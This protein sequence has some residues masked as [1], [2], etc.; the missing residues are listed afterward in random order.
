MLRAP[1]AW[2]LKLRQLL[3]RQGGLPVVW[4]A[5][6]ACALV[7]I[8]AYRML[9]MLDAPNH[10][11]LVSAWHH[12]RDPA[13][14]IADWYTLRI[15]PVPYIFYYLSLHLLMFI[16]KIETA[17]KIFLS[18]YV[19]VFPLSVLSLA[20]ALGRSP[21]LAVA[22]F[23]LAF[24]NNWPMGFESWMMSVAFFHF[25]LAA[26]IRWLDG[27]KTR[28][29]VLVGLFCA[30]TYFAHVMT[31]AILGFAA[32]GV[33]LTGPRHWGRA[34]RAYMAM[35]PTAVCAV[36][37]YL[38]DKRDHVFMKH[39]N[40]P[41]TAAWKDFPSLVAEFPRRIL[42]LFPGNL[43]MLVLGVLAG[44][45]I[46]FVVWSRIERKE[47]PDVRPL[48]IIRALL[49]VLGLAYIS[50]PY[51]IT[52]PMEWYHVT[53][54]LPAMIAPILILLPSI[55]ISGVKRLAL[56]P[57]IAAAVFLPL[58]LTHLY[59]GFNRRTQPFM[60]LVEQLPPGASTLVV[61]RGM[62]SGPVWEERSGD[63]ATA[64]A[65]FWHYSTWPVALRG[66]YSP[67]L[68]D[69]GVPVRPKRVL[70]CPGWS[71]MDEFQ[72]RQAPEFDYYLVRFADEELRNP[73]VL[74][75][76]ASRGEWSLFKR[77][78]TLTEEP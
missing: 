53:Q 59:K 29:L 11:A 40:E 70:K 26:L 60:S 14:H 73:H 65:V 54:R 3:L 56:L 10:M 33:V 20:R 19:I 24:N 58:Q 67:Y 49:W 6:T 75:L 32:L 57:T 76:I 48:R 44:T 47:P 35:A 21:W 72:L 63:P 28:D 69:Q 45:T 36:F 17:N 78:G 55:D 18:A 68:F 1:M 15:R 52:K 71:K 27:G 46:A 42:D 64:E 25:T 74:K 9:P 37:A 51:H 62:L 50:L 61:Y 77:V 7:P 23:P 39:Q 5:L 43:D 16:V 12:Y 41:F 13:W 31:W 22:A 30:L 8:W 66:G 34:V 4:I 2:L 38:G